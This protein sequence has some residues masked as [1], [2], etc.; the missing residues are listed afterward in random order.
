MSEIAPSTP[1]PS[2]LLL[3]DKPVGPT[4]MDVCRVVKRALRA[5][6]PQVPKRIKVGHGGTL[7]PLASGLLVV[8]VGKA[9][10]L[11]DVVMAGA[12]TYEAEIDLRWCTTTD[13][14]E[15][16]AVTAPEA[17]MPAGAAAP[18]RAVVEGVVSRFV[19]VIQQRPP[20]YSAMKVGGKRAYDLA[21]A[22]REVE[23]AARPVRVD[24][25]RVM[26]YEWPKLRVEVE[27]GKGTYI[28]SLAR[29]IGVAL[30]RGGHLAGLRRTR[31]GRWRVEEAAGMSALPRVLRQDDL[32]P[33]PADLR[34][35]GSL[36]G[37]E[38]A[39]GEPTSTM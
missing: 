17:A 13:D 39:G 7:D 36:R 20:A 19:G 8:L 3:V 38:A 24:A 30:G 12:K 28:R 21:R 16:E 22:G 15:G 4:S 35:G 5:A 14:R 2:G 34:A 25:I 37:P 33:V 31:I 23:L 27:C 10:P 26:A 32:R 18:D 9:T 6:G 1:T 11:C 29:D